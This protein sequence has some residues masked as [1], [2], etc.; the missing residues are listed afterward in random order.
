MYRSLSSEKYKC[1]EY[2]FNLVSKGYLEHLNEIITTRRKKQG[3]N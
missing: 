1:V 3:K 2:Q